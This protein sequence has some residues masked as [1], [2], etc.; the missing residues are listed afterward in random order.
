MAIQIESERFLIEE[1]D[2]IAE[3][4]HDRVSQ[5]LFGII[6]AIQSI[7]GDGNMNDEQ[8]RQ[9]MQVIQEAA[10]TASRELRETIYD[11][12]SRKNGNASWLGNVKSQL[13]NLAKLNGV[14]IRFNAPAFGNN[15]SISHQRAL[16]RIMLEGVS[17]AIR[18]GSSSSVEVGLMLKRGIVMLT[19]V[20]DGRGFDPGSPKPGKPGSGFGLSNMRKLTESL[21][22]KL[23]VNSKEG[24][25]TLIRVWLP[26]AGV[27]TI[28]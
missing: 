20:D 5:Q 9:Q 4:L 8:I 1:R 14:H 10:V 28:R 2:R 3:E 18:H 7:K 6:Y 12:S 22:G 24:D 23:E 21:G 19:I 25:G 13:A 11:L 15:L 16:Y 17:N 27:N 26:R